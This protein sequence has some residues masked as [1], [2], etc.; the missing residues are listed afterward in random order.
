[1]VTVKTTWQLKL[2]LEKV[3]K[4][5]STNWQYKY[6]YH[7]IVTNEKIVTKQEAEKRLGNPIQSGQKDFFF[8]KDFADREFCFEIKQTRHGAVAKH[9]E[10]IGIATDQPVWSSLNS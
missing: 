9:L 7:Y 6:Y 1:M 3:E 5:A 4:K 2:D 10:L 8:A